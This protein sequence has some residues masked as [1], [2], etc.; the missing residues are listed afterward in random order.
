MEK[1]ISSLEWLK[2]ANTALHHDA[3][4][5]RLHANSI[6]SMAQAWLDSPVA[7][8][9]TGQQLI[10]ALNI[11]ERLSPERRAEATRLEEALRRKQHAI[12]LQY[13]DCRLERE[14]GQ[15][16]IEDRAAFFG[17]VKKP[18]R[19]DLYAEIMIANARAAMGDEMIDNYID[20]HEALLSIEAKH[21]AEVLENDP[22]VL[23]NDVAFFAGEQV[24]SEAP[25]KDVEEKVVEKRP[26]NIRKQ[27]TEDIA[28][29]KDKK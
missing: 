15:Y 14:A 23:A 28:E 27:K 21:M 16:D 26:K 4:E 24:V 2:E 6:E 22:L 9:S 11:I 8:M 19:A 13:A 1:I 17:E 20:A 18:L 3:E 10:A 25:V 7:L 29:T 12:Q 5:L